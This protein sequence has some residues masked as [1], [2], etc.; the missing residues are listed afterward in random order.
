MYYSF[1]YGNVHYV[2][3]NFE[4]RFVRH[5]W[6]VVLPSYL[7][8]V[9]GFPTDIQP[10][11]AQYNWLVS[12]LKQ[13]NENRETQPWIIVYFHRPLYC[14]TFDESGTTVNCGSHAEYVDWVRVW[15]STVTGVIGSIV[16]LWRMC[17]SSTMSTL[18]FRLMCTTMNGYEVTKV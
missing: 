5:L 15:S 18:S 12:D 9:Q 14:S 8:R 7:C 3:I 13:A 6:A 2:A 16:A 11:G 17:S 10:G 1:N 4:Q